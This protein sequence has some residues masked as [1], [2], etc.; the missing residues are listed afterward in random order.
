MRAVFLGLVCLWLA[1]GCGARHTASRTADAAATR[2]D[3][4][5]RDE[6]RGALAQMKSGDC[7]GAVDAFDTVVLRYPESRYVSASLY[8]AGLCLQR[9]E[10]WEESALRYERILVSR[11]GSADTRHARFQLAF[12]Y[13]E[14]GRFQ[15]AL[16]VTELLEGHTG[17]SSDE[18][19][20]VLARRAQALL[21]LGALDDATAA[22]DDALRFYR[23]RAS[24]EAV[25]DPFFA[26]SVTY[27]RAEVDRLRAEAIAIPEAKVET[28]HAVLE[29]RAALLLSA[30]RRYFDAIRVGDSYWAAAAGYRIGAMYET[31]WDAIMGAPVAPPA[32]ATTH[33]ELT[34][35]R[36]HYRLRLAELA[37]PLLRHAIRYWELTLAMVE[38]TGVP[39]EWTDRIHRDL[40]RTRA[41]LS[42]IADRSE[43][44][45]S[46]DRGGKSG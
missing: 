11:P 37:R 6:F 1:S 32:Y 4:G 3:E 43:A 39:S 45:P 20:E 9:A 19:M 14:T 34:V 46:R 22:A 5:V 44:Q 10:R 33:A 17:L 18:R 35:F 7:A 36:Q 42:P 28:Q 2:R 38:R 41:R 21:G 27:V 16:A 13:N 12:L 26:A 40:A 31:F 25:K 23:T 15:E 29:R 30:Q 8:N 24:G